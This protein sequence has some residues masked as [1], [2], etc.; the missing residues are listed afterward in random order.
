MAA[1]VEN[2]LDRQSTIEPAMLS[3]NFATC[4]NIRDNAVFV[5]VTRVFN[6]GK[7]A[8]CTTGVTHR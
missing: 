8:A 5:A 2:A 3:N 6:T 1:R 7:E 4:P